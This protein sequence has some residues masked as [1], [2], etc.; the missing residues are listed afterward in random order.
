MRKEFFLIAVMALAL[1]GT[2]FTVGDAMAEAQRA[3]EPGE[4]IRFEDDEEAIVVT[5]Q[6]GELGAV[7]ITDNGRR[8]VDPEVLPS[9]LEKARQEEARLARLDLIDRIQ[10][11]LTINPDVK[12]A[13]LTLL[14]DG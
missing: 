1:A 12:E 6:N 2:L 8:P 4:I 5:R 9:V 3:T 7:V 13:L 10:A 14:G 11:D